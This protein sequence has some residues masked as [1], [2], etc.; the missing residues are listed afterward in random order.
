MRRRPR[1]LA[2][3]LAISASLALIGAGYAATERLA[4]LAGHEGLVAVLV[5]WL[6]AAR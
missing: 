1:H 4:D 6:D 5:H 2:S 3:Y